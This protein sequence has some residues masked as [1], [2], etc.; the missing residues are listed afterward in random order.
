VRRLRATGRAT[1][2]LL[3]RWGDACQRIS[4]QQESAN[5]EAK[6]EPFRMELN[7]ST[8]AGQR[9]LKAEIDPVA[10]CFRLEWGNEAA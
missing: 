10:P 5:K 9:S 7:E 2:W 8:R 6:P 3:K 4:E 1:A